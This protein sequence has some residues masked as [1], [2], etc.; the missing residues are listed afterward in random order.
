MFDG[1]VECL[2]GIYL[3]S[4]TKRVFYTP[5][6]GIPSEVMIRE[7]AV[8]LFFMSLNQKAIDELKKIYYEEFGQE[9]NDEEAWA[10]GIDLV[11]LFKQIC[12]SSPPDKQ[13]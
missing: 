1:A 6:L 2:F 13:D 4:A 10:M 3:H 8:T 7:S 11:N 12:L 5:L 9:L